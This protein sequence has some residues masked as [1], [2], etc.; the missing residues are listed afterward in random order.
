MGKSKSEEKVGRLTKNLMCNYI[1][2]QPHEWTNRHSGG[3]M[4]RRSKAL[5]G[6]QSNIQANE[7]IDGRTYGRTD[8]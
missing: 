1:N 6:E 7:R 3:Q 2:R 4:D 8:G 5:V